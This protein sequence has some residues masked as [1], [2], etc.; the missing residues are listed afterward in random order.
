MRRNVTSAKVHD[1]ME[2]LASKARSPGNVYFTGG[3][4]ALLFGLR[5]QT[6]DLD[7]KFEPEP[8]GIFEALSEIKNTL[9]L[10]VELA[11]PSDFIPVAVDWK[12]K[13]IFI[14]KFGLIAF[15]HFD[16]RYQALAKIERGHA[17]DLDDA[18]AFLKFGKIGNAEIWSCFYRLKPELI[19]FPAIDE[20][21]FERKLS[22]FLQ[23]NE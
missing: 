12:E 3:A 7:I 13:S 5:E 21:S 1:F 6:I 14:A 17:Q 10:N 20:A 16:L 2:R 9:N 11:S 23:A 8:Q 15:Y 4:T 19:R 22:S 18:R